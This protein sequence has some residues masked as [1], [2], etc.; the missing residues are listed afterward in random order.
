MKKAPIP[1]VFTPSNE[2]YL[3]RETVYQF[4]KMISLAL[5]RNFVVAMFTKENI[6]TLSELQ[7]AACQLIPHGFNV[8]LSIRELIRQ[9]YLYGAMVLLRPLVERAAIVSYLCENENGVTQW[10]RGWKHGDRPSFKQLLQAMGP[11]LGGTVIDI[12]SSMLMV[13]FT[14]IRQVQPIALRWMRRI[15]P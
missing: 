5:E 2:P 4:D 7:H 9:G 8:A 3:G 14:V 15:I 13:W 10:S 11:G 6:S 1:V 12:T